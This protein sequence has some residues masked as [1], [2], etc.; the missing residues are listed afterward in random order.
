MTFKKEN[1]GILSWNNEKEWDYNHWEL[2]FR[3]SPCYS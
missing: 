3:H 1:R 2:D